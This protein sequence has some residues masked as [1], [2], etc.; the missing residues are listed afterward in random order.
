MVMSEYRIQIEKA[1]DE[2]RPFLR[3]CGGDIMFHEITDEMV[4]K[5]EFIGACKSCS[6]SETT[7]SIGV[8]EVLKAAIPEIKAI[9]VVS[10]ENHTNI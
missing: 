6:M 3:A 7:F 4:V 10:L 1:L 2:I 8:Q 9:E 5:L